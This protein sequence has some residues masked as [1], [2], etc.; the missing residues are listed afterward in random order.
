MS[1]R[2]TVPALFAAGAALLATAPAAGAFPGADGR[3]VFHS[4]RSLYAIGADG[5]HKVKLPVDATG[6]GGLS[7]SADGTRV[8]WSASHVV[9]VAD[10][11]GSDVRRL[12]GSEY[13]DD[14]A[15]SPDGRRIAYE[16]GYGIWV[17]DADGGRQH[18]VRSGAGAEAAYYPAWSPDGRRIAFSTSRQAVWTMNADGTGQVNLTPPERMCPNMTREMHGE[19]PAWSP[20]GARIAF[21]GPVTCANSRGSDIWVMNA[22]GSTKANLIGDDGTVDSAPVF[23]PDGSRIAFTREDDGHTHLFTL[24]GGA[25]TPVQSG[26]YADDGPDW[27]VAYRTA[28]VSEKVS[29]KKRG[30]RVVISGRVRP[31]QRGR[32]TVVVKRGH[33]VV[34]RKRVRLKHSRF[35]WTYKP[36]KTGR[37]R[38]VATFPTG[39]G[40]LGDASPSRK[41]RARRR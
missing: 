33:K 5:S 40:V 38:A 19:E 41:F 21:V 3:I 6:F 34:A 7:V 31:A 11:D 36:R 10:I 2:K 13:S 17:M 37:Y 16:R 27:G 1:P 23:S 14:P 24:A 15:F 8:T 12:T 35:R 4:D 22:D 32:V 29:V 18:E 30:R 20:D 39:G 28:R 9:Y 26:L 25:V